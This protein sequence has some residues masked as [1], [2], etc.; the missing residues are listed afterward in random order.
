LTLMSKSLNA[1]DE[2]L[3]LKRSYLD[4]LPEERLVAYLDLGAEEVLRRINS[5]EKVVTTSSCMGRITIIEALYP[6][7]RREDSRIVLK[8]HREITLAEVATIIS[9][10]FDN[11]WLKVSGPI[12]HLRVRDFDCASSLLDLAR[13][14]GFKHSGIISLD[15]KG[16]S[17]C[18]VEINSPTQ[19]ISPLKI[20]G[21]ILLR[22]DDLREVIAKANSILREGR[23]RLRSLLK[24]LEEVRSLC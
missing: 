23:R 13:R 15:L 14:T 16:P 24:G 9:R 1:R 19:L 2:W 20:N 5:L 10:P 12:F 4:A 11:L 18:T 6:W 21:R 3:K 7:E 8:V 17:C 22:G